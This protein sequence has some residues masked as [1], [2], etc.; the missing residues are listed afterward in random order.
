MAT[1]LIIEDEKN[2]ARAEGLILGKDHSIHYAYD[3]DEGLKMAKDIRPD[4][5]ILD[6]MLPK[7]GGY[8][9]CYNLRQDEMH[10][11]LKILMVTAK[12]QKIDMDKGFFIG[13]DNYLLKPFEPL[14]LRTAVT[15]L[16][17]K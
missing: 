16:L 9:V 10:K 13:A 3:G 6:L 15:K 14:D 2:I 12:N 4:L 11:D 17:S 7:R 1:I 5:V 8:D